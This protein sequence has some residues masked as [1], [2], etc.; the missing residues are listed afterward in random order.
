MDA[1]KI[2]DLKVEQGSLLLED[3]KAI[4][5]GFNDFWA[6]PRVKESQ[7]FQRSR[8]KWLREG[9]GN[10]GYFHSS[11]KM[12]R[13]R[14]FIMP[15][16]VENRW[17]ESV[18]KVRA[19]IVAYFRDHFSDHFSKSLVDRPT[20]D[21][22]PLSSITEMDSRDLISSC[23][24]DE[25]RRVVVNSDGSKSLGPDNFN[26]SFYKRFWESMKGEMGIMFQQFFHFATLMRCFSS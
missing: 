11:I 25:I 4:F 17:F 15:L 26:F 16:R 19:E 3:T 7:I 22:V 24:E 5:K 1:L 2:L 14:D 9:D 10:T 20:L 23:N 6:L 12:R 13:R 18:P 8:T 21:G